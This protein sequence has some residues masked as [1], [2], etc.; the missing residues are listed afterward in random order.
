MG[1]AEQMRQ[2]QAL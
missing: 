2:I 1:E